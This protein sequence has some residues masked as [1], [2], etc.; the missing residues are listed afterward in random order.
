MRMQKA[1]V[2]GLVCVA[3]LA[4]AMSVSAKV[5]ATPPQN[6]G[7]GFPGN[8]IPQ[9]DNQ[10]ACGAVLCLAGAAM[11]GKS[12]HECDSYI[13]KYFE[14]RVTKHGVFRPDKT[15]KK[16]ANFLKQC[17][18]SDQQTRDMVGNA[19]GGSGASRPTNASGSSNEQDRGNGQRPDRFPRS[20]EEQQ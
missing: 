13:R 6:G 16:R 12:P 14:I 17:R 18:S 3:T 10:D 2:K 8:S 20:G 1:A 9:G 4:M 15:A 5:K 7:D 11:S 19:Y